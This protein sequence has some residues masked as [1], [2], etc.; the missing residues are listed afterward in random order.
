MNFCPLYI[1]MN[2]CLLYV[3]PEGNDFWTGN[4][5][6]ANAEETSGPQEAVEARNTPLTLIMEYSPWFPNHRRQ[7]CS[8]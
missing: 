1:L 2:F 3:S 5:A 7:V 8:Q 6:K 4:L